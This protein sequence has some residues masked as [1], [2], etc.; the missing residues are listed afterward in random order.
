MILLLS[1]VILLFEGKTKCLK[2]VVSYS[3]TSILKINVC[4]IS[5]DFKPQ[6]H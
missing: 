2:T 6:Q 4:M 5:V 1:V 3:Y